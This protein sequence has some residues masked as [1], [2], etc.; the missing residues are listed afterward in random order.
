MRSTPFVRFSSE[1]VNN[2]FLFLSSHLLPSFS[3][4]ISMSASAS[5]SPLLHPAS[6][7]ETVPGAEEH[8]QRSE[9]RLRPE[10]VASPVFILD[11]CDIPW[12]LLCSHTHTHPPSHPRI[13]S[14][15]LA[16]SHSI[17]FLLLRIAECRDGRRQPVK[18][19][20]EAMRETSPSI[21]DLFLAACKDMVEREAKAKPDTARSPHGVAEGGSDRAQSRALQPPAI[22][23]VISAESFLRRLGLDAGHGHAARLPSGGGESPQVVSDQTRGGGRGGQGGRAAHQAT[24]RKYKSWRNRGEGRGRGSAYGT[25]AA[26]HRRVPVKSE[27]SAV[28]PSSSEIDDVTQQW[29]RSE[30]MKGRGADV[31]GR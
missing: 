28:F 11:R 18:S 19:A 15:T 7:P 12:V 31:E 13:H 23:N 16:S 9:L 20:R 25:P 8:Q 10:E 6:P 29:E 21:A 5:S 22:P 1:A 30:T 17:P 14:S 4:L 27:S 24:G 3:S 2:I 26:S